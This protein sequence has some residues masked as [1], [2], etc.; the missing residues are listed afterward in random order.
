MFAKAY[1]KVATE[2]DVPENENGDDQNS[3]QATK[4]E[5]M[6]APSRSSK[7]KSSTSGSLPSPNSEPQLTVAQIS[8]VSVEKRKKTLVTLESR[9]SLTQPQILI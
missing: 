9:E 4:M 5:N 3:G 6:L 2:T 7:D 1:P 8:T